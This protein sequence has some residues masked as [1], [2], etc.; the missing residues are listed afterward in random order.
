MKHPD[1][2]HKAKPLRVV[3]DSAT[4]LRVFT[5]QGEQLSCDQLNIYWEAGQPVT[6]QVMLEAEL[7]LTASRDTAYHLLTAILANR[8]DHE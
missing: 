7:D 4:G 6:V 8:E 2:G 3:G 5:A 1:T